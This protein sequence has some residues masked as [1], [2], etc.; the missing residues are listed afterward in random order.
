MIDSRQITLMRELVD[1]QAARA[2]NWPTPDGPA[3]KELEFGHRRK[4]SAIR[5]QLSARQQMGG[6]SE[7]PTS[8]A[9]VYTL[10]FVTGW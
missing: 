6:P 10:G 4:I 8:P 2:D 9:S 7:T 5:K 3:D 1:V